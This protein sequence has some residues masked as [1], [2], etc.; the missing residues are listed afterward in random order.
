MEKLLMIAALNC[1]GMPN[2]DAALC[3]AQKNQ[4]SSWC[5]SI[6]DADRV[7]WC[8]AEV[9]HDRTICYEIHD[10]DMRNQCLNRVS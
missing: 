2:D 10:A 1:A 8:R 4:E 7:A 3:R 6:Q 5:Y 9:R